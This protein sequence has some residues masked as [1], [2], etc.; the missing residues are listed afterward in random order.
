MTEMFKVR[1]TLRVTHSTTDSLGDDS[2][3]VESHCPFEDG[4][5]TDW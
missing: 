1:V 2:M 3:D 4:P 5:Q